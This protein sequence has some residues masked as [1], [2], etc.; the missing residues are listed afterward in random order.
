MTSHLDYLQRTGW[1]PSDWSGGSF[2][3]ASPDRRHELR[4]FGIGRED[5]K[6]TAVTHDAWR[7]VSDDLT[8]GL[9]NQRIPLSLSVRGDAAGLQ[10]RVGTWSSRA[11]AHPEL[12]PRRGAV[13][14]GMLTALYPEIDLFGDVSSAVA[15]G[16]AGFALGV[17]SANRPQEGDPSSALDRIVRAMKG[18]DWSVLVLAHPISEANV[19]AQRDSVLNELRDLK[20]GTAAAGAPSP[21]G[22]AYEQLLVATLKSLGEGMTAGAW[23]TGVYLMGDERSFPLLAGL[24]R[25]TFSGEASAPQPVRV[26]DRLEVAGLAEGW[27][28][29]DAP[30]LPGPGHYRQ[31]FNFQTLLTSHQLATIVNLPSLET[32]G[33]AVN[34]VTRFDAVPSKRDKSV[35]GTVNVGFVVSGGK[36]SQTP[37]SVTPSS[38]TRHIFVAGVTGSGK[39]NTIFQILEQL[40]TA[41]IPFLVI[42]PSKTEYRSLLDTAG[43]GDL[44]HVFTVGDEQ[45]SPL[46][47]NPFEFAPGTAVSVHLDLLRSLFTASFGMWNPLPQILEQSLYRVYEHCGWDIATNTNDRLDADGTM[48]SMAYPTLSDLYEEVEETIAALGYSD[49]VTSNMRA[50]LSTRIGALLIGGKGHLFDTPTSTPDHILFERPVVLELEPLGDDD[51]KAFFMGLVLIRLAELARSRGQCETLRHVVVIEEAHR[52]LANV[53]TSSGSEESNPRAKAVEAFVNLLAEVRAYGEGIA[54]ADQTPVKLAPEL[55]K[56]TNL[57]VAHRLVA[58]DDRIALGTTMAMSDA[59]IRGLAT[60]RTGRAAVYSEG[61]DAP[62]LIQVPQRKSTESAWPPSARVA[63]QMRE[64]IADRPDA[65]STAWTRH[66]SGACVEPANAC[67]LARHIA[68]DADFRVTFAR[69]FQSLLEDRSSLKRLWGDLRGWVTPNLTPKIN[70]SA[71]IRCLLAHASDWLAERRGRQR[72]WS[73]AE[74]EA[75]G[76]MLHNVLAQEF[77]GHDT[78]ASHEVLQNGVQRLFARGTDPYAAC[79]LI[80]VGTPGVCLYRSAAA[81]AVARDVE[82]HTWAAAAGEHGT[83]SAAQDQWLVAADAGARLIEYPEDDW[84]DDEAE[85]AAS[86]GIR[87]S[88]CFAQ[89]MLHNGTR[90]DPAAARTATL[91]ILTASQ[92]SSSEQD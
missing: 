81:D 30:G 84:P 35:T 48:P 42:E 77:A 22:E 69:L 87:A 39:T 92:T 47:L 89:Q 1:M 55:I 24:W 40:A 23:R 58:E 54:V 73:F 11:D 75:F 34:L 15:W 74:T 14:E 26:W 45:V 33:F 38:L 71:T 56:S 85:R 76:Q 20:Q 44:L 65:A 66:R 43:L 79:T 63:D 70:E 28:M 4:V 37:Y 9:Y 46:R 3:A 61:D 53:A 12:V 6:P 57:K 29:P 60:I 2:T 19:A 82:R 27:A 78:T 64:L 49:E 88:L 17:P 41:S 62:L 10:V 31:P 13:L 18:S 67:Q 50:A 59:Q 83:D 86:A 21:L 80:C 72:G 7:L 36:A 51:D 91:E 68:A 52:L 8:P 5:K 16:A 32:P 90:D 25:S